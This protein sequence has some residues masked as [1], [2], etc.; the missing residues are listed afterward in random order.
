[1]ALSMYQISIPV[2]TRALNNLS[3]ILNKGAAHAEARKIDPSVFINSR[4]APDMFPLSRQVQIATDAVKGCAARLAGL[5]IPSFADTE[6]SFP[7]LQERIAKTQAFLNSV[8]EAQLEGSESKTVL[9]KIRGNDVEM[10]GLPYLNGFVL[11]N[12]FFHVTTAYAIL[13]HNGVE[14]G[15]SDYLGSN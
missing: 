7:E 5:D 1:M 9:L 11:P 4:L 3:A 14:L 8:T 15:K 12:L 2:F 13:R 6:A 10:K